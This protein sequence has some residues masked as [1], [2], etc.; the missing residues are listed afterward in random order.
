M[1]R[2][3]LL[4]LALAVAPVAAG[5]QQPA[6]DPNPE[7]VQR[8]AGL[9]FPDQLGGFSRTRIYSVAPG[10]VSA[11]YMLRSSSNPADFILVDIFAIR[12]SRSVA[13][14]FASGEAAVVQLNSNI[15]AVRD[16]PAPAGAPG[17]LGRLWTG[18]MNGQP[19]LTGMYVWHREGWR[20]KI[21]GT[22]LASRG[23]PSWAEVERLIRDF[24]AGLR[25][26]GA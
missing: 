15:V 19:V 25:P 9:A 5:A 11:T 10:Q 14:D 4:A 22:F 17:A 3:L 16:L 6:G 26:P 24:I 23:E 13:E 21:R 12:S 8:Q 18:D 7:A 20:I 2:R 1:I